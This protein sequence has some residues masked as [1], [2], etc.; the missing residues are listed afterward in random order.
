MEIPALGGRTKAWIVSISFVSSIMP[1]QPWRW[2]PSGDLNRVILLYSFLFNVHHGCA[3]GSVCR[4][5]IYYITLR[6]NLRLVGRSPA[7]VSR[8]VPAAVL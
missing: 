1:L 3:F 4:L 7:S 2:C 8:M 5:I 6:S